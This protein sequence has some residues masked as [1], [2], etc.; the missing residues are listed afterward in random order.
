MFNK[1]KRHRKATTQRK[2]RV[3]LETSFINDIKKRAYNKVKQAKQQTLT[4][5]NLLSNNF[6]HEACWLSN[7]V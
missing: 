6:L 1:Q 3:G 5:Q 7:E 2:R 4:F